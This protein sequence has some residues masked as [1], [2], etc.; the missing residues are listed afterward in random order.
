MVIAFEEFMREI[1]KILLV[2]IERYEYLE[3]ITFFFKCIDNNNWCIVFYNK[4]KLKL[5][6]LR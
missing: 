4:I 6:I 5:K 2:N 3:L 1:Q